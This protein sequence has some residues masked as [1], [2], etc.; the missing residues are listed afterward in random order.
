MEIFF[1][2]L[3]ILMMAG[4]L[5]S[6]YP[7]AFALP[8]SAIITIGIGALCGYIFAGDIDTYFV[9]G[10]PREWLSTGV[11]NFRGLYWV[12]ERDIL[13]AIP[14]FVF[15]GL[16]LQRSKIAEDLLIAMAQ[17][18]GRVPGGLG[19]SVVFVGALL[20]ATTGIVGATVVAMGMV[21]LPAMLRNNYSKSLSSGVI[22]ATGTLGQI[23]PPSIV[24]LILVDQLT[25]AVN[26]ASVARRTL[27]TGSSGEYAMPGEFD[28]FSVS[29][30]EMFMGAFIPG[31]ILAGLYM[32]YVLGF[33]FAR[34]RNAPVVPYHGNYDWKFCI[35]VFLALVPP[36]VLIFLV[37]G[38]II[39][40]VAT[41]NQAGAIGAAGAIVMAGYRLYEGKRHAHTPAI[42]VVLALVAI[43]L[44][45]NNYDIKLQSI[46][47]NEDVLGV[48][49][50]VVAS[51][52]LT[53]A[54]CWSG[55]RT[56]KINQTMNDVLKETA[57]TTSLVFAILMGAAMLTAA[58]RAFGGEV[59]VKDFLQT[60]PGGF[61]G[62]F[63][64]VMLVIFV[65]GFFLDFIEITVVVVPIVAPILLAD[66]SANITAVW[67]GVMIA[68]NIQTSFLT[69]PFGF[70]LFYLRGVASTLVKTTDIYKGVIPFIVIQVTALIVVGGYP[71]LVNYLPNRV[72]L[73]SESAPPPKNPRLQY[74]VEEFVA[75]AFQTD[76][77]AIRRAIAKAQ[78]LNL[79]Q[80][81]TKL[82]NEL[83]T[84]FAKAERSFALIGA[85]EEAERRVTT[86]AVD[87]HALHSAVRLLQ[88]DVRRINEEI[89]KLETTISRAGR[90]VSEA[91][92]RQ[93][94]VRVS[95]LTSARD[96]LLAQIPS[97]W[98]A[99]NAL[100]SEIQ[101][102][103]NSARLNY[104]RN[105]DEVYEPLNRMLAIVGSVNRLK[106]LEGNLRS[107]EALIDAEENSIII[108]RM[109]SVVLSLRR[110]E[111]TSEITKAVRTAQKALKAHT[112]ASD[113]AKRSLAKAVA[114]FR[115]DVS[116]RQAAADQ[117][118]PELL[119]YEA[120]ISGTIGLRSKARLPDKVALNVA[121]CIATPR[122]VSLNF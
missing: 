19:L 21:S 112:P 114:L 85:I 52:L 24:L 47:T 65:L 4:A 106:A 43:A 118:L 46:N 20:A 12:I 103:E 58:F 17:L 13:I 28:V 64:I 113:V 39:A 61:W 94:R 1:L 67:L 102:A 27:Y 8:G 40:G 77:R 82:R 98:K 55:W 22:A 50:A 14:L 108:A 90:S 31:L 11:T 80:V 34:P 110:I 23:V 95:Y 120:A 37:L 107:L 91:T 74:C 83:L 44:L 29:A 5:G 93:A 115:A 51:T 30:G 117:L 59:L 68:M 122:D 45:V 56:L 73:L 15:M 104:R 75:Q 36:L 105:A 96:D 111:G 100:F 3:L 35:R 60:L 32:L 57:K 16:M 76:G 26:Q 49:L 101:K 18:F 33:A 10:G 87:Y 42:L 89:E 86:M 41:V 69:P 88:R 7:V 84:S 78:S 79:E 6:G 119:T 9:H 54:L 71:S 62:Q 92:A 121:A 63:T 48:T 116:W 109:R 38:S 70:A 2:A 72:S 99:K 66:P 53:L 25:T 81:P 97:E